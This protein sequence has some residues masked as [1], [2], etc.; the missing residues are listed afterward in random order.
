MP[1][2]EGRALAPVSAR[3]LG[4]VLARRWRSAQYLERG[5]AMMRRWGRTGAA[6]R[7]STPAPLTSKRSLAG[8]VSPRIMSRLW[9]LCRLSAQNTRTQ[10]G[11]LAAGGI[12]RIE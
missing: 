2:E 9:L 4:L 10:P 5:M 11:G 7:T 1:K 8:S 12:V 6:A 3:G